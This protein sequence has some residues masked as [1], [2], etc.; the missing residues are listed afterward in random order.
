MEGIFARKK[1][2]KGPEFQHKPPAS[3][4]SPFDHAQIIAQKKKAPAC[5]PLSLSMTEGPMLLKSVQ[6][7]RKIEEG[8]RASHEKSV[9]IE[10]GT[11]RGRKKKEKKGKKGG[12]KKKGK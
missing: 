5:Q 10:L 7:S 11:I 3:K 6:E 9:K 1:E 12:E 4:A 2:H 8:G